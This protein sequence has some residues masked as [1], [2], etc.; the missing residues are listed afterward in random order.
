MNNSD[1]RTPFQ[2]MANVNEQ[3]IAFFGSWAWGNN[4]TEKHIGSIGITVQ[5]SS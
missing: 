5:S 1:S 3:V 4:E 2:L